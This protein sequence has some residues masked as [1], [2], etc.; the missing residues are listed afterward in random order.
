MKINFHTQICVCDPKFADCEKGMVISMEE[1]K[2]NV[3]QISEVAR[4]N[5]LAKNAHMVDVL[6][7]IALISLE[8]ISGKRSVLT[9]LIAAVIGLIPVIADE[10]FWRK[11]KETPAI[12]HLVAMG[13]AVFYSFILFTT[14]NQLVFTFVIPMILLVS[15]FN[16]A[17]Y[18]F[19]INVGVVIENVLHIIIGATTGGLGYVN[20]DGALLQIV[21][22]VMI[23][24]YS[25]YTAKTLNQNAEQ[26]INRVSE[27]QSET[28]IVLQ[29]ISNLSRELKSG[30]EDISGELEKLN[31]A[32]KTTG[33]AMQ[34]VSSGTAD[35]ADAVQSQLEQTTAIQEKV[36]LANDAATRITENMQH[37]LEVLDSG[38]RDVELLVRTVDLSVQ[39]G[40][41]VAEKLKTLDDY[42]EQMN[43]IV[44][45]ISDIASQT[46]LLALNASI[47]AAR[48]GEAGR[49]FSVVA[50]EISGMATRTNE[51][52]SN[53][54]ALIQNVATAIREVVQVV[55]QMIDGINEEK[56]STENTAASFES[57]QENT[58]SIRDNIGSLAN[59]I[60][61]LKNANNEIMDTIQTISAI[62]Q[63]V[64]AHAS[65]TLTA[66]EDNGAILDHIAQKMQT[67][68]E[69]TNQ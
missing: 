2:K 18:T 30:I 68:V 56:Q 55:Q 44:E 11:D 47:E 53:I 10:V 58:H 33:N 38:N 8:M 19:I 63:E 24:I 60:T 36:E 52:T 64:S 21:T 41:E 66:Q 69:L 65:E 48:A 17:K 57:I 61:E 14:S 31:R 16:D 5:K 1:Q 49:G 51:A 32:S 7:V 34:Q 20:V 9:F 67:L 29:N 43:S 45:L 23:G 6:V 27:A 35:T 12:K 46:G 39:N 40:V 42:I 50:T 22:V 4:N 15:I 25:Y 28:E 26:K 13:Y 54:T 62:S 37:T 59:H 3:A